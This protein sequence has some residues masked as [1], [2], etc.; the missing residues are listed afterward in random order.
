MFEFNTIADD[1][2]LP[3]TSSHSPSSSRQHSSSST[4]SDA[5]TLESE[6]INS[7]ISSYGLHKNDV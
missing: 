2:S 4:S 5:L 6:A 7:A 3:S 1:V